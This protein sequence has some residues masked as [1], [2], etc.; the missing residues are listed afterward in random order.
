M[1]EP[2]F[3]VAAVLFDLD[4]TLL[5]TI[6]DL[7]EGANRMLAE[8]G[9]PLRPLAEIHSFV[10]KGIPHLV[11]RCMTDNAD[12]G[13]DEIARAVEVFKRHYAAVNGRRT[14]IYDGVVDTLEALRAMGVR[15]ACVTNKAGDFTLPLLE[16]MGIADHFD[17]VVCGD[18]L[19]VKKP[20]PAT[21]QH[22]CE[23]LGVSVTEALLVG[24]SANDAGAAQ[25][26]GMPVVL[27]RYGYSEGRPVDSIPCDAL[28]SSMPE[29]LS[30]IE[31][32]VRR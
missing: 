1:R 19:S 30:L 28:L 12:A 10:G 7:A 20:D 29:I 13:E 25:A 26:A 18:T 32:A 6:P 22:A 3:E 27:M 15:C 24:D 11:R 4:G 31:V 21:V 14:R 5:D 23:L 9:R 17:A 2:R 8:L 16:R